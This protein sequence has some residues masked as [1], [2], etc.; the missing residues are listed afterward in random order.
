[1]K[2]IR[3]VGIGFIATY[4]IFL[5]WYG[6][7]GKPL[8]QAEIDRYIGKIKSAQ[9][10]N[11]E[12]GSSILTSLEDLLPILL[13]NGS[14]PIFSAS[15]IGSFISEGAEV[16]W[17]DVSIVRYRSMRDFLKV[18]TENSITGTDADKWLSIDKTQVFPVKASFSLAIVPIIFAA[19][20]LAI[21]IGLYQITLLTIKKRGVQNAK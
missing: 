7:I 13:K 11:A 9:G 15:V 14:H 2:K 6:G 16:E 5:F 4:V 21:Y 20:L 8:K 17:D 12:A 3:Y 1:M 18:T 19:V 10:E